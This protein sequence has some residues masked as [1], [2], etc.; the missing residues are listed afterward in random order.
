MKTKK[1]IFHVSFDVVMYCEEDGEFTP[2]DR[3]MFKQ[4]LIDGVYGSSCGD[5]YWEGK[6]NF[7]CHEVKQ[8]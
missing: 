8:K 6:R 7:R 4:D 5:Y 1:K 2:N 3:K